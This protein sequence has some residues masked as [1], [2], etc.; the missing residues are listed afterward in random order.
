MFIFIGILILLLCGIITFL[1]LTKICNGGLFLRGCGKV[2]YP[3]THRYK[4][5]DGRYC[6]ENCLKKDLQLLAQEP[7][8]RNLRF[9]VKEEE[10]VP[11]DRE[12]SDNG[13]GGK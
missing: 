10:D 7:D 13:S 3:W 5:P 4:L 9:T 12:T 1:I 6:C 2:L 11:D 8:N